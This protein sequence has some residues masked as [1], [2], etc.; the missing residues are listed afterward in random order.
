[1][2]LILIYAWKQEIVQGKEK[3]LSRLEEINAN[4]ERIRL[5][6]LQEKLKLKKIKLEIQI[7]QR[8]YTEAVIIAGKVRKR[9]TEEM[10]ED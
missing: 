8:I 7:E 9:E 2:F 3:E 4:L 5:N 1:M 10:R 6:K